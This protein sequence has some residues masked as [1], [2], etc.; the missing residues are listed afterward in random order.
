MAEIYPEDEFD[1]IAATRTVRGAHRRPRKL[2]PWLI[3]LIAVLVLAPII[4]IGIGKFVTSGASD[5]PAVE[6][7]Q[8]AGAQDGAD[9]SSEGADESSQPENQPADA[10]DQ[11]AQPEEPTAQPT[12]EMAPANMGHM[13]LVLNGRGTAG[14]AT[15]QRDVLR[16]AG[17]T[18][19]AAADY[20][21]G[22]DPADSTV[23]YS[24][25]EY[26]GTAQAAA[27]ALGITQV[28]QD[29]QVT[30]GVDAPVVV[31]LR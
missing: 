19:T 8:S 10:Q 28:Q 6:T 2:S 22:D 20:R 27:D 26:A 3:A 7:S 11:T 15:E 4:G 1:S 17:F 13:V 14:Y 12:P 30:G 31:V 16:A 21:G 25:P 24:T 18:N 9:G 29:V 23:F 5:S